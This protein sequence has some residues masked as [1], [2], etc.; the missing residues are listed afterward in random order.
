[1][2]SPVVRVILKY[3][4]RCQAENVTSRILAFTPGDCG[5]ADPVP[6]GDPPEADQQPERRPGRQGEGHHRAAGVRRHTSPHVS[7]KCD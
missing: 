4:F 6:Q 3:D 5:E 7:P 1:M 2:D